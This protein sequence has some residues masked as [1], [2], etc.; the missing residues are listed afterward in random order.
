LQAVGPVPLA[1]KRHYG[2]P[3]TGTPTLEIDFKVDRIHVLVD[4]GV[5]HDKWVHEMD[6][7]KRS[8]VRFEYGNTLFEFTMDD[9]VRSL[10]RLKSL[11]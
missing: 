1:T 11:L 7:E 5:H 10:G 2:L 6:E 4:G 3:E 9:P 8:A